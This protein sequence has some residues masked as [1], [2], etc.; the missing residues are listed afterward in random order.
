MAT[1]VIGDVQG[2]VQELEAM[3]LKFNYS[4][5]TDQLWLAGDLVNR[6]PASLE[7]LELL[8]QLKPAPIIVLGN[9]DLHLLAVMRNP[10]RLKKGDTLTPI[11][12]SKKR[13]DIDDWYRSQHL[14][15]LDHSH[16][17]T[18]SH[19]GIFPLWD[20]E[21]ASKYAQEA[22]AIMYGPNWE[23]MLARLYGNQ[24]KY[25]QEDLQHPERFRFIIN[26]FT[27]MRFCD[28]QGGLLLDEKKPEAEGKNCWPWFKFPHRKA[29]SYKILFGHWAALNGVTHL[30]DVIA[31]DT[32]CVWGNQL[33]A[34]RLEDGEKF[35]VASKS[36]FD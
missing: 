17:V 35:S 10:Q 12:K 14:L 31:L 27:R 4:S 13:Y 18:L 2:C 30:K 25:W 15:H 26:A 7:V 22:E 29:I 32:G 3:L 28:L 23:K 9:H 34:Y 19:A 8:M 33:T 5:K 16:Q 20:L 21:T 24:P 1:Y 6:G 36:K 11:L